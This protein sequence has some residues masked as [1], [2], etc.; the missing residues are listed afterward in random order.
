MSPDGRARS[1][2]IKRA[3]WL[4]FGLNV[5]VA[6]TKLVVGLAVGAVALQADGIHSALDASSNVVGLVGIT[7]GARPPDPG[8]PYGHQRFETLAA[9]A[10]GLLIGGSLIGVLQQAVGALTGSVAPPKI[11]LVAVSA[12]LATIVLNLFISRY[13]ARRGRELRSA[14]LAADSEHTRSDAFA[15]LAVLLGFAGIHAGFPWADAVAALVVAAYIAKT[16][17]LVLR[18]NFSVLTDRAVLDAER[19]HR[20]TLSVPGVRG[21]HKIRS[22]GSVDAVHLDLHIHLDPALP[23]CEAHEKTHEVVARLHAEFPELGDVLIHTEPAD[24]REHD[25]SRLVPGSP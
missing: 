16:A 10:I 20:A 3:L 18:A 14:I 24:G 11:G 5:I 15:A 17:W 23:L 6:A 4:V 9:L 8:H 13:E 7:L 12:V 1:Q 2:A 25:Q 19:V 22:R 21:A